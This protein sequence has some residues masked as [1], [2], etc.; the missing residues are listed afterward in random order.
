MG[1]VVSDVVGV[2]N[3][4]PSGFDLMWEGGGSVGMVV[5]VGGCDT[6]VLRITLLVAG[7]GTSWGAS[8]VAWGSTVLLVA[9]ASLHASPLSSNSGWECTRVLPL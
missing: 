4:V 5:L 8:N 3:V 7:V 6:L 1:L 9:C 2:L